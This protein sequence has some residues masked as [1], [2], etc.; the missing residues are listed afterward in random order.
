[1]VLEPGA[2]V[3]AVERLVRTAVL[4]HELRMVDRHEIRLSVE[5]ADGIPARTHDAIDEVLRVRARVFGRVDEADLHTHPLGCILRRDVGIERL[6]LQLAVSPEAIPQCT[7][8]C[9]PAR[10]T[11]DGPV[12]LRPE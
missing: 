1:E 8:S 7:L 11:V 9:A 2:A 6:D 4:L 5:V 12:V 3:P 10:G